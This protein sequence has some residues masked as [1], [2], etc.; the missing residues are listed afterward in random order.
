MRKFKP[1]LSTVVSLLLVVTILVSKV[2]QD[3]VSNS[4]R[5]NRLIGKPFV[6]TLASNR[7]TLT[8]TTDGDAISD[9]EIKAPYISQSRK[10]PVSNAPNT[11]HQV[12][13][14]DLREN[15]EYSY[16]IIIFDRENIEAT[17]EWFSFRTP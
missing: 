9:I 1:T 3:R 10:L 14:K 11:L 8:F 15:T 5:A 6:T 4:A 16:R 17:S 12:T 2:V 7:V 13:L